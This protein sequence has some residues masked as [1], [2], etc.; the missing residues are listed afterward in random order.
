MKDPKPL[1]YFPTGQHCLARWQW[2]TGT[3]IA[4]KY[5]AAHEAAT[6]GIFD[7]PQI[8][9]M[10][11]LGE[12]T[13]PCFDCQVAPQLLKY[14]NLKALLIQ[15]N[16]S[17]LVLKSKQQVRNQESILGKNWNMSSLL[18]PSFFWG[19]NSELFLFQG[20]LW[21]KLTNLP[22]HHDSAGPSRMQFS[23][24]RRKLGVESL[25]M[26]KPVSWPNPRWYAPGPGPQIQRTIIINKSKTL[27]M[28]FGGGR[29]CVW[30][31]F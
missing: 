19:A 4:T 12:R 15:G 1:Q 6:W 27:D 16:L 5:T 28:D 20:P 11:Q 7:N 18:K 13:K 2:M 31:P 21:R 22:N 30:D 10:F 14:K 8:Y 29:G 23:T 9:T 26:P 25:M 24:V 17:T 3:W